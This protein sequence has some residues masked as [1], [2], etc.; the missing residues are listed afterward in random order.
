M[1]TAGLV[2]GPPSESRRVKAGRPDRMRLSRDRG[3]FEGAAG[4]MMVMGAGIVAAKGSTEAETLRLAI[5][6]SSP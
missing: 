6:P 5:W 1:R 2:V 4:G 3:L